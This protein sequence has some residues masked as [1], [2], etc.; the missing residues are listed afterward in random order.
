MAMRPW[1]NV[2]ADST[3]YHHRPVFTSAGMGGGMAFNQTVQV[4]PLKS[5]HKT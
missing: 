3:R 2:K 1:C 4:R 5:S